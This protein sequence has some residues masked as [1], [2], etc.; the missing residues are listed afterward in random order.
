MSLSLYR[1]KCVYN[2]EVLPNKIVGPKHSENRAGG[3]MVTALPVDDEGRYVPDKKIVFFCGIN[4]LLQ[5]GNIFKTNE[6]SEVKL[7]HKPEGDKTNPI[8]KTLK[9]SRT[10]PA[11]FN[12]MLSM[13]NKEDT[14][15]SSFVPGTSFDRGTLWAIEVL[16]QEAVRVACS[17]NHEHIR[18]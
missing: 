6:A 14:S 17:F 5:L 15:Q 7:F 9:L 12:V 4:D 3:L 2:F 10:G 16:A 18:G 8:S 11:T 13:S 1:E